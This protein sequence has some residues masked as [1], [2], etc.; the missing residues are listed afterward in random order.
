MWHLNKINERMWKFKCQTRSV[1]L[2]RKIY[3]TTETSWYGKICDLRRC[4]RA[5]D[6]ADLVLCMSTKRSASVQGLQ[7]NQTRLW[8]S[9]NFPWVV[10]G[11]CVCVWEPQA[12]WLA[13]HCLECAELAHLK[14]ACLVESSCCR[15]METLNIFT[16]TWFGYYGPCF[17]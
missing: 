8:R 7:F 3:A 15:L 14:S 4:G 17:G 6:E 13:L 2:S 16:H 11:V 1:C 5:V 12:A 9:I 10:Q